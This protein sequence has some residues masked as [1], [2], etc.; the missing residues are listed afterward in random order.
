MPT[1]AILTDFGTQDPYVG[2]MKGVIARIAPEATVIDVTHGVPPQSVLV[3]ALWLD[4]AV[5]WFPEDTI[6]LVVVDPG[7][8]SARRVVACELG[9]RRF[10]CPD[11]GLLTPLQRRLDPGRVVVADDPAFHLPGGSSTFHG[12]DIMSPVAAHL[13]VGVPI[14][15]LGPPAGG[16]V[17]LELPEAR[18]VMD[19]VAGEILY[20]DHFG[21]LITSVRA[22]QLRPGAQVE[23]G[24]QRVP[25]LRTYA[26][27]PCGEPL[28]LVGSTGRLEIS[29]R[30]GSAAAVLELGVGEAVVVIHGEDA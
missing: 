2:I 29:V 30:D 14:E 5:D 13:A 1:I 10:V 27:V 18:E 11:N 23:L 6:F 15:R 25:L 19:M 7:V 22:A 20:E 24:G 3:G 8:G 16:L 12:R 26:E 4:S 17:Q 28:A 9:G 21:N